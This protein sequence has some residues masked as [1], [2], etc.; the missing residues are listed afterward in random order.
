MANNT[1]SFT[2]EP[3][4]ETTESESVPT[5]GTAIPG[6]CPVDCMSKF[7][8]FLAVMC[9]LKFSGGTGRAS[10]FLVSVRCV[11]EKDKTVAM[12]FS[13]TI[14]SLFAFIPS[15]IL[16]GFIL[17]EFNFLNPYNANFFAQRFTNHNI[18]VSFCCCRQNLPRMG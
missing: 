1:S 14:M 10:N 18:Y 4:T 6:A 16:F 5:L 17:G 13:L 8:V 12:G 3:S 9:L 15:P 11:D 2:T 7:Y